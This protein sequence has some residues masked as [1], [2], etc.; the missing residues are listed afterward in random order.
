MQY[1]TQTRTKRVLILAVGS[2]LILAVLA[3]GLVAVLRS[4]RD[5]DGGQRTGQ[6]FVDNEGVEKVEPGIDPSEGIEPRIE[7]SVPPQADPDS[8]AE[9]QGARTTEPSE[10]GR[11]DA[12]N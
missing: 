6:P 3:G 10:Q 12:S 11:I 8:G 1:T 9:V 5:N 7:Q 4:V 2:I